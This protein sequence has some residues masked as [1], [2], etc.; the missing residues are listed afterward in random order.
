M[1]IPQHLVRAKI[2]EARARGAFHQPL[3]DETRVLAEMETLLVSLQFAEGHEALRLRA[4]LAVKERLLAIILERTGQ[5]MLA[6]VLWDVSPSYD[7][8]C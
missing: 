1:G 6:D 4:Q 7:A 5:S 3:T 8:F 2:A